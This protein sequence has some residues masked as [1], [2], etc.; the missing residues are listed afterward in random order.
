[1]TRSIEGER[2]REMAKS[3]STKGRVGEAEYERESTEG[4]VG[5]VDYER[6]RAIGELGRGGGRGENLK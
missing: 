1:M 2:M 5:S 4:R 3:E 6:E